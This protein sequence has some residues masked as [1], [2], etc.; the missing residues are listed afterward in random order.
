MHTRSG[1]L[2]ET[3]NPTTESGPFKTI[4]LCSFIDTKS[5]FDNTCFGSVKDVTENKGIERA[6][7][8]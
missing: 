5:A 6:K 4:A 3:F 7:G 1:I 2:V 8:R